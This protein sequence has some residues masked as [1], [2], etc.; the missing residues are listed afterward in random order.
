M[1]QPF[2]SIRRMLTTVAVMATSL[3][4]SSN[5]SA[6]TSAAPDTS[7]QHKDTSAVVINPPD[8]TAAVQK[9]DSSAYKLSARFNNPHD[10]FIQYGR[11]DVSGPL[12]DR[13]GNAVRI[14][15]LNANL[16][17]SLNNMG[18]SFLPTRD[19]MPYPESIYLLG[20]QAQ[21]GTEHLY[22]SPIAGLKAELDSTSFAYGII[23]GLNFGDPRKLQVSF[24]TGMLNQGSSKNNSRQ[25]FWA[26]G[27]EL[28]RRL[29]DNGLQLTA[30]INGQINQNPTI[31]TLDHRRFV[32]RYFGEVQSPAFIRKPL[33]ISGIFNVYV[34]NT[35]EKDAEGK[36]KLQQVPGFSFGG[37]VSLK[38]PSVQQEFKK[39]SVKKLLYE[40]KLGLSVG[41]DMTGK[42]SLNIEARR[43][44]QNKPR[45]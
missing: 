43:S 5:A 17:S 3:V 4:F 29:G 32:Y 20:V 13:A 24:A 35:Q 22:L 41:L 34:R 33:D 1:K 40:N 6:Q 45:K 10:F 14:G 18:F 37:L 31:P 27:L 9:Q 42:L 44:L 2:K 19:N 7:Q 28:V 30:G 25:E 12:G 21:V 11:R 23:G 15:M 8:S 39:K 16:S 26:A 36:I 38:Q